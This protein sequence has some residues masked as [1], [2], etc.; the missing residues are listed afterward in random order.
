MSLSERPE[1]NFSPFQVTGYA[2]LVAIVAAFLALHIVAGNILSPGATSA[3][4]AAGPAK[5]SGD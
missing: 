5:L 4:A 1:R 2:A 3:P